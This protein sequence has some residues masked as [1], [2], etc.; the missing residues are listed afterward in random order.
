NPFYHMDGPGQIAHLDSLL[1]IP[2]L[3]GIQWVPGA[4]APDIT[5][6]PDLYRK[7]RDSGKLIQIGYSLEKLDAIAEQLGSPK[8]ILF[9]GTASSMEEAEEGLRR[10]GTI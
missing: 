1:S 4:G 2:E 5:R 9:I 6:W 8:G 3:K 7:I 10:Y